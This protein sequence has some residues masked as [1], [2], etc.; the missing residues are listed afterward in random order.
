MFLADKSLNLL[1][2]ISRF[3]IE[4]ARSL[5][6][7]NIVDMLTNVFWQVIFFTRRHN[8]TSERIFIL[9]KFRIEEFLSFFDSGIESEPAFIVRISNSLSRDATFNEPFPSVILRFLGG[10]EGLDYFL[11][12]LVL[13]E[14][15]G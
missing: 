1:N 5:T 13:P 3:D 7:G 14:I 15:R 8:S 4:G 9:V 10:L 6:P 12:S 11:G 2:D